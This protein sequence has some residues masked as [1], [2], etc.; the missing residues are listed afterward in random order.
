MRAVFHYAYMHHQGNESCFSLCKYAAPGKWELFFIMQICSTREMRAVF[1][2][3]NMRHQGNESCFSLCKYVAPGIWELFFI[4]QI[5]GTREMR[6]VFH[7]AN[8]RHQR[9]ESCFSLCKYAAPGQDELSGYFEIFQHKCL[10][11]FSDKKWYWYRNQTFF[12]FSSIN[13]TRFMGK[14]HSVKYVKWFMVCTALGVF[15]FDS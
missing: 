8:M 1:H 2:Y 7:Y 9:N 10:L 12:I 6:A 15:P 14:Q 11:R 13:A 3:A 4:M 5:C